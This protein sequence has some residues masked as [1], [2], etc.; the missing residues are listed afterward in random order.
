MNK[1]SNKSNLNDVES[2]NWSNKSNLNDK[3]SRNSNLNKKSKLEQSEPKEELISYVDAKL[4]LRNACSTA[5]DDLSSLLTPGVRWKVR[6]S[7]IHR[8]RELTSNLLHRYVHRAFL[9]AQHRQKN[10]KYPNR[11]PVPM[12][13]DFALAFET[14]QQD[15]E[16]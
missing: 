12:L 16:N 2:R 9:F 11:R 3:E 4:S 15:A 10:E 1:G 7:Y 13:E 5:K 6:N 8:I 14:L